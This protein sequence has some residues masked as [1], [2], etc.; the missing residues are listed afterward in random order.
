MLSSLVVVWSSI[1]SLSSES[2]SCNKY[3][4]L[5]VGGKSGKISLWKFR[6]PESYTIEHGGA[7]VEAKLVGLLH[8]HDGWVNAISWGVLNADPLKPQLLLSTGSSDGR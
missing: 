6:H 4:I 8:A 7:L 2:R 1:F 5:A 3:A